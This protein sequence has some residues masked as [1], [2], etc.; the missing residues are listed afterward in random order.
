MAGAEGIG[1]VLMNWKAQLAIVAAF[2]FFLL[3]AGRRWGVA[4]VDVRPVT[5]TVYVDR[6]ITKRDTVTITVPEL[7]TIYRTV[8]DTIRVPVLVPRDFNFKGLVGR[9]PLRFDGSTAIL[10]YWSPSHSAFAQD[11][12]TLP[13]DRWG[14]YVASRGTL[15]PGFGVG[16]EA[17]VRWRQLGA[18]ASAD[19]YRDGEVTASVGLRLYVWGR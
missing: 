15:W 4:S 3:L 10:T 19:V 8:T 16:V 6:E 13:P 9:R 2:A 12:Y 1:G 18:F 5:D 11:R 7:T 14:G 17:G